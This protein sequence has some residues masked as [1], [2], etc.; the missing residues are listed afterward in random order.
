MSMLALAGASMALQYYQGQQAADDQN[1]LNRQNAENAIIGQTYEN[2]GTNEA[3]RQE[4]DVAGQQKRKVL[5]EAIQAQSTRKAIGKATS[6]ASVDRLHQS[7][8]NQVGQAIGDIKYNLEGSVRSSESRKKAGQASTQS[9]INS[10]PTAKYNP[11]ADL[12]KG[13]L[14]I[15]SAYAGDQAALKAA[16]PDPSTFESQGFYDWA[17]N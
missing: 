15:A 5:V 7:L 9:R 16:S 17:F 6:G 11:T 14:S 4:Q 13:G 12:V 10:V 3:I 1:D 8:S 2:R